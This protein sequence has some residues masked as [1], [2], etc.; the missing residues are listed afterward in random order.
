MAQKGHFALWTHSV[1]GHATV[2]RIAL[3]EHTLTLFTYTAHVSALQM[4]SCII[5]TVENVLL[6]TVP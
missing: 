5:I 1:L 3:F 2:Y 4:C 6:F